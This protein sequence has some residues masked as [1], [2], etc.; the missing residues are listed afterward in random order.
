MQ[1]SSA[2]E[3]QDELTNLM[4]VMYMMIQHAIVSPEELGAL[5]TQLGRFSFSPCID[6]QLTTC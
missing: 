4:T 3:V 2:Q 1:G 5:H 6:H